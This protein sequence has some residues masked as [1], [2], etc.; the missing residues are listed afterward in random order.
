MGLG[1]SA[2]KQALL[3]IRELHAQLAALNEPVAIVGM[4]CRYPGA[5]GVAAF[6]KLLSQ[7]VD[8]I[9]EVPPERW[10][11]TRC[12]IRIPQPPAR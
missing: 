3:A 2:A 10:D 11:A 1:E 7:G 5:E 12:T 8:A 4:G 9:G 6:W